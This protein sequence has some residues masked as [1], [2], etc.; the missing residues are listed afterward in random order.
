L[1]AGLASAALADETFIGDPLLVEGSYRASR[2][3]TSYVVTLKNIGQHPIVDLRI[4]KIGLPGHEM[5]Y[6]YSKLYIRRIAPKATYRVSFT[7]RG[8]LVSLP[9]PGDFE[10]EAEF[11]YGRSKLARPFQRK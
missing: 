4:S 10:V 11:W 9:D 8:E 5:D 6:R 1:A 2:S 7:K 3:S